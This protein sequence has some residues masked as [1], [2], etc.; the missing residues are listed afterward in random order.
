MPWKKKTLNND[1][2]ILMIP[3]SCSYSCTENVETGADTRRNTN[4][5]TGVLPVHR[6]RNS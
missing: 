3:K 6:A 5:G 4:F 2:K 1:N